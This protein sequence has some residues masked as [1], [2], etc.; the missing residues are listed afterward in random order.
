M[1]A[2]E[3]LPDQA[4]LRALVDDALAMYLPKESALAPDLIA[5]MRYATLGN[6]KRLRP[7][8]TIAAATAFG[9]AALDALR[10]MTGQLAQSYAS[11]FFFEGALFLAA[12]MLAWLALT[13]AARP[14]EIT[15][16]INV[17]GE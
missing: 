5:A 17:P 1:T 4:E 9:A 10:A 2:S 12:A 11:V 15:Y 3:P 6:G 8:L 16:A 14:R 7:L 13:T